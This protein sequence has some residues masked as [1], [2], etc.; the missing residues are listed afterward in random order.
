M[1][2]ALVRAWTSAVMAW[3]RA[4]E[5]PAWREMPE[6]SVVEAM[7][8]EPSLVRERGRGGRAD[9]VIL[10]QEVVEVE[11]DTPPR[12]DAV[13]RARAGGG[14]DGAVLEEAPRAAVQGTPP[15]LEEV[16]RATPI[17]E[18][19]VAS[20]VVPASGPVAATQGAPA[21]GSSAAPERA[22]EEVLAAS[23]AASGEH[24]LVPR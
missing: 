6:G 18:P 5:E 1:E 12:V 20:Q 14:G 19:V 15:V 9:V 8:F 16:P 2:V 22:P 11:D 7:V 23:G 4:G 10:D 24:A 17:A 13:K 21:S 3:A